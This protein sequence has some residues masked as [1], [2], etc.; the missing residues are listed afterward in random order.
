MLPETVFMRTPNDT[1]EIA[2]SVT[3][4]RV[5]TGH[6]SLEIDTDLKFLFAAGA[7]FIGWLFTGVTINRIDEEG[8]RK[9][10]PLCREILVRRLASDSYRAYRLL[11]NSDEA[12][13]VALRDADRAR[14]L[15]L[16][17][18]LPTH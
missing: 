4:L 13:P 17:P 16:P 18:A 12:R 3:Q 7:S 14:A 8:R 9:P 15:S 5:A 1:P 6:P 2:A 10:L 11:Q